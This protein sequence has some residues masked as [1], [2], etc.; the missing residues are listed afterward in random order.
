MLLVPRE[1]TSTCRPH[2]SRNP[3]PISALPTEAFH[4]KPE[5]TSIPIQRRGDDQSRQTKILKRANYRLACYIVYENIHNEEQG[6]FRAR[7][8]ALIT[9]LDCLKRKSR[10]YAVPAPMLVCTRGIPE[11]SPHFDIPGDCRD[12]CR[13]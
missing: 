10:N 8:F 5:G 11:V 13:F 6:T 12:C 3:R 2:D 9:V 4:A 1:I 7:V